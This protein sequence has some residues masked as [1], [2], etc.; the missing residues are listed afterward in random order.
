MDASTLFLLFGFNLLVLAVVLSKMRLLFRNLGPWA[1]IDFIGSFFFM[2]VRTFLLQFGPALR[3]Y[4]PSHVTN[5]LA[6]IGAILAAHFFYSFDTNLYFF[7]LR[8]DNELSN[9]RLPVQWSRWRKI[10]N[11][12]LIIA[13][14]TAVAV[15]FWLAGDLNDNLT[16]STTNVQGSNALLASRFITMS[17][18]VC[19]LAS[20]IYA[21]SK[22][23]STDYASRPA[24]RIRIWA[25]AFVGVF[26][27]LHYIF[28]PFVTDIIFLW[29]ENSFIGEVAHSAYTF[30]DT[31]VLV[32]IAFC[33]IVIAGPNWLL[34]RVAQLQATYFYW[35]KMKEITWLRDLMVGYFPGVKLSFANSARKTTPSL[36]SL[37]F[38][39]TRY[40]VECSDAIYLLLS[41][42]ALAEC[43]RI[44][45]DAV[46]QGKS[47]FEAEALILLE[48]LKRKSKS[49]TVASFDGNRFSRLPSLGAESLPELVNCYFL[50][51]KSLKHLEP[52][53]KIAW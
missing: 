21:L 49:S 50:I 35:K 41:Y 37:H 45:Q 47:E 16:P 29:G 6:I 28:N 51:A 12:Y 7:A 38:R 44:M 27:S 46:S 5:T 53:P 18:V 43:A 24:V 42:I 15:E 33:I 11:F 31:S 25:A 48:A 9:G 3:P 26:I 36:S 17:Y 40:I 23:L 19:I 8:S 2:E 4:S 20:G 52:I 39:M 32:P 34:E 1:V 30:V 22:L 13:L 14:C 10:E